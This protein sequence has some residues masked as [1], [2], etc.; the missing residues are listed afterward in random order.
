[1]TKQ[2]QLVLREGEAGEPA[3]LGTAVQA[4]FG[5]KTAGFSHSLW[6]SSHFCYFNY[7]Y[8]GISRVIG[9][10]DSKFANC[11]SYF[12]TE[13]NHIPLKYSIRPD[14]TSF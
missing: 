10:N 2:L 12:T 3:V 6:Q 14:F 9:D 7:D 13:Q 4:F 5:L 11:S 8:Q 1:M